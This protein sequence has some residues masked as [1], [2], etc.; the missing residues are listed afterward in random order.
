MGFRF[1]ALKRGTQM[2]Q[3][4][5]RILLPMLALVALALAGCATQPHPS[6]GHL[7]GFFSGVL[8]GFLMP[9]SFIASFF[10]DVRIYSFPNAGRWYDFGFIIGAVMIWGGGGAA[11]KRRG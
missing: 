2:F 8:H 11:G 4:S 7:P 3:R 6:S 5:W 9:F 10:T 1:Q